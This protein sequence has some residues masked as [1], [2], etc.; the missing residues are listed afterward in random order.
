MLDIAL[1][2]LAP[3][4]LLYVQTWQHG[5]TPVKNYEM[6]TARGLKVSIIEDILTLQGHRGKIGRIPKSLL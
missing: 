1:V 4:L 6:T 3:P 5:G 2:I